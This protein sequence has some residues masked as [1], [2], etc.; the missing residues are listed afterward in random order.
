MAGGSVYLFSEDGRC[1]A[2]AVD[3]LRPKWSFEAPENHESDH[4]LL[5]AGTIFL[6]TTLYPERKESNLFALD[7]RTGRERW[8]MPIKGDGSSLAVLGQ[9][10]YVSEAPGLVSAIDIDTRKRRWRTTLPGGAKAWTGEILA[11]REGLVVSGYGGTYGLD[12]RAGRVRWCEPNAYDW[13]VT[14]VAMKGFVWVPSG[15]RGSAVRKIDTGSL[16]WRSPEGF[17][18]FGTTFEGAF[19]GYQ[20]GWLRR[21][22]FR[23]GRLLSADRLGTPGGDHSS[24]SGIVIGD[25]L[26]VCGA[27]RGAIYDAQGRTVWKGDAELALPEPLGTDA[28]A[29]IAVDDNR[30]LRYEPGALPPTPAD[31]A[32]RRS[33]AKRLVDKFSDLDAGELRRLGA[34]QDDAFPA[35]LSA[36]EAM[37]IAYDAG[38]VDWRIFGRLHLLDE[39]LALVTSPKHSSEL[40]EVLERTPKQGS[41]RAHLQS[42]LVKKGDPEVVLPYFLRETEKS[43]THRFEIYDD[44]SREAR[45]YVADSSDPRA[46]AFMLRQLRDPKGDPTLRLQAFGNLARTGGEAGRAA[47]RAYRQDRALLRPLADRVLDDVGETNLMGASGKSLDGRRWTLIRS[48]VLGNEGDYWLSE[49]QGRRWGNPVFTG[50]REQDAGREPDERLAKR[51]ELFATR[52]GGKTAIEWYAAGD[53]SPLLRNAAVIRDSDGDGVTDLAE[54]RLGT[55]PQ[56]ADTDSDGDSD[57]FDPWP[58]VAR[59]PETDQ[60][61]ALAAVFEARYFGDGAETGAWVLLPEGMRSFE[62][63][64]RRGVSLWADGAGKDFLEIRNRYRGLTAPLVA[65]RG[66]REGKEDE[67]ITWNE[68]R[69]VGTT[70]IVS[71]ATSRFSYYAPSYTVDVQKFGSEWFVVR[72]RRGGPPN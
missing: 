13:S 26:F 50:F 10:L 62:M 38:P 30:L 2:Y 16:R 35:L 29:L 61:K 39:A 45:D 57:A 17:A 12:L 64:G 65:F 68:M 24:A 21:F 23:D 40:I 19:V 20:R 66:I 18:T 14:P 6:T 46:V 9:T 54:K 48:R 3:T 28:G 41:G 27:E 32:G 63:V 59:G 1:T 15:K 5:A 37:H 43:I 11:T 56:K 52:S 70:W 51:A 34:L 22:A 36:Y 69:T 8:R 4:M 7:A 71:E 72:I 55:D 58:S 25:R 49:R 44:D 67:A 31:R 60:E 42:L 53:W 33:L 47:I